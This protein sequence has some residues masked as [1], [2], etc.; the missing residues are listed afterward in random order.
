MNDDDHHL[1]CQEP[2]EARMAKSQADKA[3]NHANI[4]ESASIRFRQHG[5]DGVG[6]A[7]LMKGVGMTHG[8]F[9][10]HFTSRD[11]LVAE[12]VECAFEEG[13]DVL[14]RVTSPEQPPAE[15]FRKLVDGYL[16][17]SHRDELATSCALTT[18]AADVARSGPAARSS[19][20]K[21][22]NAYLDRISTLVATEKTGEK[23]ASAIGALSLLV[24]AMSMARAVS[25]MELSEEI[26]RSAAEQAK[27]HFS[28]GG[29]T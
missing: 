29:K 3:R 10:R 4:V 22:V 23:R 19:Y 6:V 11:E 5:I 7:D 25:D 12:A 21:Q 27:R 9:Y 20:T 28:N 24:G 13:R 2:K 16:N 14:E 18:L 1:K 17:A 26:L 15:A 8:G